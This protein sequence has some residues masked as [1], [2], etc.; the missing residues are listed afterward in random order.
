MV[1]IASGVRVASVID[2][3]LR[4]GRRIDLSEQLV[5]INVDGR[6][7]NFEALRSD[8]A[9]IQTHS[10]TAGLGVDDPDSFHAHCEVVLAPLLQVGIVVVR[11]KDLDHEERRLDEDIRLRPRSQYHQVGNAY[12]SWSDLHTLFGAADHVPYGSC[13]PNQSAN[14]H[15]ILACSHLPTFRSK[16]SPSMYSRSGLYAVS[17][18]SDTGIWIICQQCTPGSPCVL[19]DRPAVFGANRSEFA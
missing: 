2:S 4:A 10:S 17:R 8:P 11:R 12:A 7:G 13:L 19:Q 16:T 5:E 9:G 18:Y 15:W 3:G 14:N 6:A 1:G